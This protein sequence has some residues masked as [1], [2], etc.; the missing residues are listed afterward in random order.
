MCPV[1]GLINYIRLRAT[2]CA[3]S[4]HGFPGAVHMTEAFLVRI[5]A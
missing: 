2:D 4:D 3:S 1:D 5:R